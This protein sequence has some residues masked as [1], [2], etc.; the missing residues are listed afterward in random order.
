[1]SARVTV[2]GARQLAE[3]LGTF[4]DSLAHQEKA[5]AEAAALLVGRLRSS[6]PHRTGALSASIAPGRSAGDTRVVVG[7]RYAAPVISGVPRR[8]IRPN[9]FADRV[10]AAA[11]PAIQQVYDQQTQT[12]ASKIRGA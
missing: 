12:A 8:G 11:E 7:V 6:A 2:K 5:E 3:S 4:A 9:R 1:M 10:V